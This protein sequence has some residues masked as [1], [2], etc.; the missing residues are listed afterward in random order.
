MLGEFSEHLLTLELLLQTAL[1][2]ATL[3]G[4]MSI[5]RYLVFVKADVHVRDADGW[6]ALHN[7]CSK[8]QKSRFLSDGLI[9]KWTR[10]TSI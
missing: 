10:D 7:A 5:I 8:V 3:K 2:K 9:D 1:H 4:H 6:T